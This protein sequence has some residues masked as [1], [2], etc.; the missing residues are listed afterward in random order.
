LDGRQKIPMV[1]L[2]WKWK[3]YEKGRI[4]LIW[5]IGRGSLA[6]NLAWCDKKLTTGFLCPVCKKDPETV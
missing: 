3:G 4:L 2:V 5:K 1:N 6:T